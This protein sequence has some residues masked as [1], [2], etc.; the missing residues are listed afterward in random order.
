MRYYKLEDALKHKEQTTALNLS[1]SY[2]EV[3]E[4]PKEILNF[5]NLEELNVYYGKL[6]QLPEWI[7]QLS[8]LKTL[9]IQS[10]QL[11]TIPESIGKLK[12]LVYLSVGY[13]QL[14]SI[15]ESIG[16]LS[17]LLSLNLRSNLLQTLP[18][19]I[20]KLTKLQTL[21]LPSNQLTALPESIGGLIDLPE[22]W[23]ASNQ[24]KGLPESIGKLKKLKRIHLYRNHLQSLPKSIEQLQELTELNVSYNKLKTLPDNLSKCKNLHRIDVS[25]NKLTTLPNDLFEVPALKN[26]NLNHNQLTSLPANIQAAEQLYYLSVTNNS[27]AELPNQGWEK[28]A[29]LSTVY[30][31]NNKLTFFPKGLEKAPKLSILHIPNN[32]FVE[33]PLEVFKLPYLKTLGAYQTGLHAAFTD[34]TA[35]QKILTEFQKQST[36]FEHRISTYK[37][38]GSPKEEMHKFSLLEVFEAM[39][40][41]YKPLQEKAQRTLFSQYKEAYKNKPLR[42]GTE[43]VIWGTINFKK[44]EVKERLKAFDIKYGIKVKPKTTHVVVGFNIKKYDGYDQ[45]GLVFISDQDLNDFFIQNEEQYL[46]EESEEGSSNTEHVAML[47][48]STDHQNIGLAFQILK[49]GGVPQDLITELFL[50]TK[51][52]KLPKGLREQAKAYI[53]LHGSETLKN[54]IKTHKMIFPGY[55]NENKHTRNIKF[56][57]VGTELNGVKV[58]KYIYEHTRHGLKFWFEQMTKQQRKEA[59]SV[60]AQDPKFILSA[61]FFQ[62]KNEVFEYTNVQGL[63]LNSK[64]LAALPEQLFKFKQLKRLSLSRNRLTILPKELTQLSQ[65]QWLN[66]AYNKMPEFPEVLNEMPNLKEIIVSSNG[67]AVRS[68][69]DIDANTY[70]LKH[71]PYSLYRK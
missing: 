28:M 60:L 26:L 19:S 40:I 29:N 54:R 2:K 20:G 34:Y 35:C 4:L 53:T 55:I 43:V 24:L 33:P 67:F 5:P 63:E 10:C 37:I 7:G 46:L 17:Q 39:R 1:F 15:P 48:S 70:D 30:L 45:E 56:Y 68:N 12:N 49:T 38:L 3:S 57:T 21:Y 16:E 6:N 14:R 71:F 44:T 52:P 9:T 32:P 64:R 47:L 8:S 42:K 25:N 50:I 61:R 51:N 36:P 58:G 13:N 11:S 22:L 59:I 23:V 62:D 65:L 69:K 31:S 27:I 18:E 41:R 66:I